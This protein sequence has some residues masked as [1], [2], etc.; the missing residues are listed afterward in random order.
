MQVSTIGLDLAK[1]VFQVHGIDANEKVVVKKQLRRSQVIAFFEALPPCLVGLE[2]CATSH[3]WARELRKLGH[4]VR[5]MPA[6]RGCPQMSSII[7][8]TCR[9]TLLKRT[10]GRGPGPLTAHPSGFAGSRTYSGGG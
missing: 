9:S 8:A 5:L 10:A 4:E 1:N 2:A 3:H 6:K 7:F